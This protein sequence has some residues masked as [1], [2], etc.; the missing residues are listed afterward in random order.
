MSK[1]WKQGLLSSGFPLEY[2]VSNLLLDS[3]FVVEGERPYTR[4]AEGRSRA[5]PWVFL[6][7]PS[8]EPE[9]LAGVLGCSK[10]SG[11]CFTKGVAAVGIC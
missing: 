4:L 3:G 9:S 2:E 8:G 6:A 5:G 10:K 1:D 7:V 11:L